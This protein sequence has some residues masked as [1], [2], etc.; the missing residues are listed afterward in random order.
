MGDPE[1][2]YFKEKY[3]IICQLFIFSVVL[4]IYNSIAILAILRKL[5][6]KC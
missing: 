2:S 4:V 6:K 3:K 5:Y 1:V